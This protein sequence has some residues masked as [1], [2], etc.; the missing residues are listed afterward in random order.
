MQ[1]V[2]RVVLPG[3]QQATTKPKKQVTPSPP[4]GCR[5]AAVQVTRGER[6]PSVTNDGGVPARCGSVE[7]V[8]LHCGGE[9]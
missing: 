6:G 4:S 9:C 7:L 1:A 5:R 2:Q 3:T 8:S